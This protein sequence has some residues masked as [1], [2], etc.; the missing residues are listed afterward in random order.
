[1]SPQTSSGNNEWWGV[2]H[3]YGWVILDRNIATNR[4]GKGGKLVFLRCK[5]WTHFEEERKKWEPPHYVFADRYLETLHAS[6]L[7]NA[8]NAL[9]ELKKQ[10]EH[11]KEEFYSAVIR[12]RHHQFLADRGLS[13]RGTRRAVERNRASFCWNCKQPVDNSI[14]LE[15]S[16]CRWI[17]CGSCGACGCTYGGIIQLQVTPESKVTLPVNPEE[18][19]KNEGRVFS[20]FKEASQ[21]AKESLGLKLSR[22][23]DGNEWKVE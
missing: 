9:Q 2:S 19:T 11:K 22:T 21:Y 23:S 5:D 17:I 3:E 20:S 18:R 4:P 16:V 13:G 14:D 6:A 12:A 10:F 15:C 8:R 7:L 1:M